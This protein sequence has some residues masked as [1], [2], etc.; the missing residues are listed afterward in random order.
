MRLLLFGALAV[1]AASGCGPSWA[2]QR[3][4]VDS[5]PG[6]ETADRFEHDAG[7]LIAGEVAAHR[8][9]VTNDGAETMWIKEDS[10][11]KMNCG[12]TSLVPAAK[13]LQPAEV[14][15]VSVTVNTTGR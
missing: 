4:E 12:C 6:R 14:T 1:P 8:F 9:T 15:E 13:V 3:V 5:R 7:Q 11:I 10:H 2:S